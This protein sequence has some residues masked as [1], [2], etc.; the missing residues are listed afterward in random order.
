[1]QFDAPVVGKTVTVTTRHR[2]IYY[3]S[4]SEWVDKTY[5]G[6][7]GQPDRR[8]PSG[9]FLLIT[10]E[11]NFMPTRIIA[12]RSVHALKYSDGTSPEKSLTPKV[13]TWQ[14]AGSKGNVYTVTERDGR[15]HCDCPGFMY[16]KDC[17]HVKEDKK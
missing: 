7:V 9:S 12:L 1:M 6:V 17:K 2:D 13:R 8:V 15:R 3:F 10:P 5:T 11:D 4:T 14:V 16:R